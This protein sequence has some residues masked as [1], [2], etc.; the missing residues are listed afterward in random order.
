MSSRPVTLHTEH[1]HSKRDSCQVHLSPYIQNTYIV[2]GIVVQSICHLTYRTHTFQQGQMSSRPVTL[3][4][5]YMHSSRDSC[6]VDLSPYILDTY[7]LRGIVV[8][9]TCHLTYRTHIFYQGQ[10]SSRPVSLHTEYIHSTRDSCRVDLSPYIQDTYI[11]PGIVVKST[12]HPTY[13]THT[14]Y[15][16][17]LSSRPDSL[18]TEYIHSSRDSYK[19]DL[20]PYIQDTYILQGIVVQ[21]TCHLTYRTHTFQQGQM[22][23]R[24]VTLH[25]EYMHSTRD[26]CQVDMSPYIQNTYILVGIVVEST[27]HPIYRI[28]TFYQGQLSSR[29]VTLHTEYI[30]SRR[31]SCQVDLST[32]IQNTYIPPGIVVQ[33]TCHLTYRTHTFQQGQMS[34]RP[35][36]LHTEYMHS[37]RDSC[38]VDL[39][40]YIQNTYIIP[41]I[42]VQST[43]HPTY[44]IHTLYQEQLSS[45]PVT[46]HTE[47]IHYTKNSC[48]V[49]LSPYIQN[50]YII[51]GISVKSTCH[52]TYRTHTFYQGQLSSRP[53][54][55]HTEYIHYSR[56]SYGVDLSSYIQDT[57]ILQGIVVQS[58]CHLTYIT[59]TFQQGQM[60]SRPVTLHTEYMHS[61]RDSYGVDLS[62][63]IQD[64][65]ILPGIVVQSTCHPTYRTHT[66]YQGQLS[67]RPVSLHT[68]YIHSSRDSYGVDLSPY[69][70]DTYILPGI[71]VQSTCHLTYRAHTFQQGQMSSRPVTLHTEYM[72]STRDSCQVDLSPYIQNTYILVGII[73]ESTCHPIYRIHTFYQGQLSSRLVTL[74]TEYIQSRRDSCQVDLSPHIQNT[75]IPP[76]IVVQ[77]TC[78]LTYR[79]HTFQQGQL[80][81]RPVT[82]HTEYIHYTRNSCLVDL[83][84]YIKN[85]YIIPGIVVQ[86][87]CHPTYRIHTLYQEQ[88][89]SR[90]VTLHTEYIHYTRDSC[91]VNL[92]PYIQNTYILPGI[93]VKS[94]CLPTYRIHTFQQGQL[95]SRP[96]TLHTGHIYSTRDSCLVDLSP[97]I[98]NTHIPAGIIVESTCHLTYRIHAFYQGQMSSRPVTLHTVYIHSTRDS[99]RVD[100]SPYIQN[101]YILPG[102]VVESTCHST[103]RIHTVYEGQLS[104][105]PVTLHTEHIYSTRDSCLV[106]LS[107][108]IQN[109]HIPAGIDVESTC[110]PT[111]RIHAF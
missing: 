21:S 31:D 86:S 63:Y 85:T 50:T 108:H 59:H 60:S 66:F 79:T 20:S 3:H 13:R 4:T 98:H 9:S 81:S 25:T 44:R 36:T 23:S 100:L 61:S 109:T 103:Y 29:L 42:V 99:C 67:S 75:Y 22:S 7:I 92:S 76:G 30:Q 55:L 95:W 10:L 77:S 56:D 78:H 49:D 71:V 70:Q 69:I 52:P 107:P 28:H 34:S 94:T 47:Y 1:I 97:Y 91:Q 6:R 83:S 105:R 11:I 73:V 43:C 82:L 2:P 101:T 57:Y 104:N 16:G 96:V 24:P 37:S 27:C 65:Y 40:P 8:K 17:Q 33:S 38:R 15:Q 5:E 64:T 19:V 110:H 58:T 84:P 12:C 18:H 80:S 90:P 41:G 111:Y 51:P 102:I 39:S 68:E 54:S 14:F 87:T 45:R 89:S 35:V 26:S 53:V 32:Q 106:V 74:H 72:H 88:L 46:L 93:V 48:L 62:P